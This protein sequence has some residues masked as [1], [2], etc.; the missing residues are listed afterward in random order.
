MFIRTDRRGRRGSR[1]LAAPIGLVAIVGLAACGTSTT[2]SAASTGSAPTT[3][4]AGA[5]S[6]AQ[7]AAGSRGAAM[8]AYRTCLEQNGV[9]LPSRGNRPPGSGNGEGGTPPSGAPAPGGAGQGGAGQGGGMMRQAPPGVDA[10]TWAKAQT[11]CADLRPARP[12]AA[13]TAGSGS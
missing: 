7:P 6:T 13:P 1:L 3:A 5:D 8:E 12:T 2:A 4:S 11:A 10:D 9:T